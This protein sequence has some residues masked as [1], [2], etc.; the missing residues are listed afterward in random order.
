MKN[1]GMSWIGPILFAIWGA[2]VGAAES[3]E[4]LR[5]PTSLAE[6][7]PPGPPKP[8]QDPA[9]QGKPGPAKQ[10]TPA[11][12]RREELEDKPDTTSVYPIPAI[13]SGKNEGWT[14]GLLAALLLPDEHGDIDK[15][16]SVA[17]QYRS[18]VGINGF[19]DFRWTL[20][21]Y[22]VLEAY[23]YWAAK[24]ENEN[25]LFFD[26]RRL[27]R[28]Y[29]FRVD[30]D[31]KRVGT[32]RF[33][34]T[35]P[36]SRKAEESVYTSNNYLAQI[37]FGPYI[38]DNLSLQG[39]FRY[40]HFRVGE[41]LITDLPQMLDLFPT[42]FGIDG[43]EVYAQGIRLFF[44]TRN[45]LFTPTNGEIALVYAEVAHYVDGGVAHPFQVY[46]FELEKLWPHGDEA[47][48]VFVGHVRAQFVV[49]Q[50]PFWELSTL[51]G[52]NSLR[53]YGPNR[54]TDN[55]AW[56]VN[57]EERIRLFTL[58]LEGVTGEVQ[59]APFVD[60]GEVFGQGEDV[61]RRVHW[62]VGSGFRAVV[63]PYIVGRLDVGYGVEGVGITI[64]LDYP[65]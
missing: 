27:W 32:E 9:Q 52:G 56:V 24:V 6:Q 37:R 39:T 4:V 45:S 62:S 63:Y 31:E 22:S 35:G 57:L 11:Q 33:F 48:F 40:R 51:G 54:F 49:G 59:I 65:F 64:A 25:Q 8:P 50:A 16:I 30:F 42:E 38:A 3:Q 43:G 2:G 12:E 18:K 46:G 20:S 44:D 13:A 19:A 34:G 36:T 61:A 55:D 29:N 60:F 23:S 41:S 5:L 10:R 47:Q 58:R 15:V 53:S 14:Y 21:P 26:D 17:L 7:E 28:D 1:R